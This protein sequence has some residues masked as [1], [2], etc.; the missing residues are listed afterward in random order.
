[1]VE[2][3]ADIETE[4]EHK[5]TPLMLAASKGNLEMV[6]ILV[7]AGAD[8]EARTEQK[9]TPLMIAADAGNLEIV[10]FLVETGADIEARSR[11]REYSIFSYGLHRPLRDNGIS[12]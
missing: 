7:E 1:M 10:K 9:F 6:K 8:I 11:K 3:G 4:T 5:Y 2:G 12:V